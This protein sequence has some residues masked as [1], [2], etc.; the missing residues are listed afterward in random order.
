MSTSSAKVRLAT[1]VFLAVILLAGVGAAAVRWALLPWALGAAL[2]AGGATDVR[3]AV[4][5]ASPWRL[6]LSNLG[7][8][9]DAVKF[10]AGSASLERSHW[11]TP[12]LGRL[13]VQQAR[14]DV[15]VD[16]LASAPGGGASSAGPVTI[17]LEEISIDGQVVVHVG[18]E[19][20]QPLALA[21]AARPVEEGT[22]QGD[23][24]LTAPGLEVGIQG[25]YRLTDGE[26]EFR[27]TALRLDLQTWQK[28][29]EHWA[30]LPGG[31]WE[32]AGTLT[33]E[34]GGEYQGGRFAARGEFHLR[35]G[36]ASSTALKATAEGVSADIDV[37]DLTQ[38]LARKSTLH[39]K[40]VTS[41]AI[42]L[43]D[44]AVE[45]SRT[46]GDRFDI[47]ALSARALGGTVKVE[48]FVYRL[49]QT[50]VEA[51]ILADG[52]RAEEVMALTQ[53]LPARA[54]G[55]LSGRLPVR[56]DGSGVKFGTGWLG[57][58]EGASAEIQFHA[59]GMLTAGTSPKSPQYAVLKKVEDGIL[60]L[61][62][63]EL[64]LDIRPP[65]APGTRTAQLHVVGAPVDP[66][67]KAPVT[68]DLNVNGPIESLINLG[69]KSGAS[70]GT[71][72]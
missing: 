40:T 43:S 1:T 44:V 48:P 62:V 16:Q 33:G 7:F 65:N 34:A 12:S 54:S 11:W 53:D 26:S 21:F 14:V 51:V 70:F 32:L 61:K 72:P 20:G 50:D 39:V 8:N 29:L 24:K 42:V 46:Q 52:I 59:A 69:L 68:L 63:T 22:W 71:K 45:F 36:R 25:S 31:P 28:W 10:V 9:F 58:Q 27:S 19:P 37:A 30:P 56:Y 49:G 64:R 38:L 5:R 67:V 3:F 35:D 41:G 55:P 18:E 15:N 23:A 60:K 66:E 13:S 47:A 17:P 2:K 6:Q 4:E 57:L